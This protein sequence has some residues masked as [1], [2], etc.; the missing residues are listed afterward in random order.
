MIPLLRPEMP[1]GPRKQP[2]ARL[3]IP[4]IGVDAKVIELGTHYNEKGELVW[5]TA[6]FSAGHHVGTANPGEAGNTVISGHIS[7]TREGAVFS[8]LPQINTGDGVVVVTRDRDY[9]YQ[10]VDKRVVDPTMVE[11]MNS[12]DGEILTILTCVPDGIYSH[13]LV[14]TAKRV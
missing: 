11:V 14:V 13:R 4:S 5:E 7:S 1:R 8:R 12:S 9:V 3:I 2:P 6:P 10:V